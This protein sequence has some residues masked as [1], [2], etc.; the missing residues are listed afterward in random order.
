MR[1]Y[2]KEACDSVRRTVLYSILMEF[3]VPMKLVW[4]I[5]MCLTE[6]YSEVRIGKHLFE[7]S[8]PKWSKSRRCSMVTAFQL[9]LRVCHLEGPGN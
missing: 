8:Y 5:K 3:G 7:F 9:C 4:L 6:T 2:F 1:Q